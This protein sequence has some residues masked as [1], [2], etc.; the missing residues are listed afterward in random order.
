MAAAHLCLY[1][2]SVPSV[3]ATTDTKSSKL[4]TSENKTKT[5]KE[6]LVCGCLWA[7]SVSDHTRNDMHQSSMPNG[8]EHHKVFL[9][10][11]LRVPTSDQGVVPVNVK[12][13]Y[14]TIPVLGR[15]PCVATTYKI[16][17]KMV[18]HN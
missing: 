12:D 9:F 3:Y 16:L 15:C 18:M 8:N 4:C 7:R 6:Q 1:S 5:R 2:P 13:L 14:K 10:A 17:N 11:K